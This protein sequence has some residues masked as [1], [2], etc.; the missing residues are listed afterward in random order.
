MRRSSIPGGV[1][2]AMNRLRQISLSIFLFALLPAVA[3]AQSP[4]SGIISPSRAIDWTQAGFPGPTPPDASW[5]QCG[6]T[7]A[8]YGTSGAPA[9]GATITNATSGC[10]ANTYVQLGAGTFYLSSGFAVLPNNVVVRGQGANSTFIVLSGN[11]GCNGIYSGACLAG[12]NSYSGGPQNVCDWTGPYTPGSTVLTFANCGSTAPGVGSLSNLKVGSIVVLDQLD[13]GTDTGQIW[14]CN[15]NSQPCIGGAGAFQGGFQRTDGPCNLLICTRGQ[16]QVVVVTSISGSSVT[17]SPGVYMPNWRSGQLPQAWFGMA[18]ATYKGV[19]DMSFDVTNA[20][21]TSTVYVANCYKCWVKGIRS[22]YP[23]RAAIQTQVAKNLVIE[24]NYFYQGQSHQAVS[25]STEFDDVSDSLFIN[26]ICQQATD[27]CPNN[28]GGEEGNV[29]AYNFDI[30][31]V[32]LDPGFFVAGIWQHAGGDSFDLYEGNIEPGYDSDSIHGTHHLETLYRNLFPGNQNA[33]CGSAGVNTCTS[34]TTPINM[35]ASSRY[36]N[37]IGN[38][39]GDPGRS[40]IG[41]YQYTSAATGDTHGGTT[42]AIYTLGYNANSGWS[43]VSSFAGSWCNTPACLTFDVH[44]P[45]TSPTLLR[46]GNWDS[47]TNAV[48]WC[49]NSSDTGWSATCSSTSEIPTS[50]WSCTVCNGT[51]TLSNAVPSLG[52]TAAG[53]SAMPGSFFLNTEPSFWQNPTTGYTPPFPPMG[54]DVT[55]GNLGRCSGGT[56]AYAQASKNSD[57]TPGGGT[58]ITAFGGHANATPAME[59]FLHVMGGPPD[60]TGNVLPFN[61]ALCYGSESTSSG[62]TPPAAPT[63]LTAAVE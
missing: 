56:Y 39:L 4:W 10:A 20:V 38:I 31:D 62:G 17:V 19:E 59:C 12:S 6:S 26:N 47:V 43:S 9:S 53:Q 55:G 49:G 51:V 29:V 8:P 13:E 60:G 15:G 16:Q 40:Q 36:Y 23:A 58:L 25:Y 28:N 30:D 61:E 52:D 63:D 41:T 24:N 45:L 22:I 44:D 50:L 1:L 11:Y 54:P 2:N 35:Y 42:N 46:W 18:T 37:I 7:I 5:I 21:G 32:F 3:Q 14:N 48:R 57:C 33:G 27:S 34:E